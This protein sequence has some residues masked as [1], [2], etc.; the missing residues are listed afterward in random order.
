MTAHKAEGRE[1]TLFGIAVVEGSVT[2]GQTCQYVPCNDPGAGKSYPRQYNTLRFS[3]RGEDHNIVQ[4][5]RWVNVRPA[6]V[7]AQQAPL[8]KTFPSC[9]HC[10]ITRFVQYAFRLSKLYGTLVGGWTVNSITSSFSLV[11]LIWHDSY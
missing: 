5:S 6:R 10:L 2:S 7:P 11:P 1:W 8:H 3:E 9:R 4:D